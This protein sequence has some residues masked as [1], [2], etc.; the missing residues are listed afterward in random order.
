VEITAAVARGPGVP[1]SIE[2]LELEDPRDDEV[3][4][5]VV[6]TGV[7]HTDLVARDQW[8][9]VPAPVVL[10]HEGAGIVERVGRSVTKVAPGDHVVMSFDSCGTCPSCLAGEASYCHGLGALN[11]AAQRPDG[12]SAL[13]RD[14]ELIHAHFFGQSSFATHALCRERSVVEVP[15]DAPLEMIGPLGCGV[16]TGAGAVINALKVGTGQSLAVFGTGSVGLSAVMAARVVGATTIIGFDLRDQRLE[17]ALELGATHTVN[18]GAQ[19]VGE[20]IREITGA[21]VDFSFET[22]GVPAVIRQAVE[23]L[24]PRG[25]CGIVGASEP[26]AEIT[27]DATFMMSQGR[28]L[29]GIVE[30]DSKPGLFIPALIDL[31]RQGRFPLDELVSFYPLERIND[32]FDDSDSGAAVKPILRMA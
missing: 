31:Y 4:V 6:A 24:A 32:A 22:T 27:L 12:T 26:G 28:K 14:G 5:R 21:G 8:V 3:I 16:Q 1:L 17:L 2:T 25:M 29:R 7:C 13:S 11:F 23:S 19:D 18:P 9:P 15:A 30:G 20:A 10:G